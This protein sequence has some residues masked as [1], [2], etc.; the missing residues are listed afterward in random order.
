MNRIL[1]AI[2]LGLA[3]ALISA[4]HARAS[5]AQR[6]V[7]CTGASLRALG[8]H[9]HAKLSPCVAKPHQL[10]FE[11][12]YYQN[13]SKVGGTALAAYPEA[14]LR[15]GLAPHIE[16][17]VDTPSEIAKSGVGGEGVYVM[18]HVGAGLKIEVARVRGVVY[19]LSAES[20]PPM[21]ALANMQLVPLSDVHMNANWSA[22]HMEMGVEFGVLNYAQ[23][24][25]LGRRSAATAAFSLTRSLDRKTSVTSELGFQ[26]AAALGAL[27]QTS[28]T[29]SVQRELT[30]RL[31]FNVEIG[32]AFNAT[33]GSK[34]HYLG[35]GFVMH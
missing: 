19:S 9:T 28:A 4:S 3:F 2:V 26:S 35:A 22:S 7:P 6:A 34:P 24:N 17:F 23:L 33:G 21:N 29:L 11:T 31:L 10:I 25:D 20:H 1:S 15:Y 13:A 32:T 30:P 27:A 5:A 16:A 8:N 12:T 18:T 14:R